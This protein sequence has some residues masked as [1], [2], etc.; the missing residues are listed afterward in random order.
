M[1]PIL[2]PH[3]KS[4]NE[5]IANFEFLIFN[6]NAT[7]PPRAGQCRCPKMPRKCPKITRFFCQSVRRIVETKKATDDGRASVHLRWTCKRPGVLNSKRYALNHHIARLD[8]GGASGPT[9]FARSFFTQGRGNRRWRCGGRLR[10]RSNASSKTAENQ[11]RRTKKKNPGVRPCPNSVRLTAHETDAIRRRL[12]M[13]SSGR[14][15]SQ[16]MRGVWN[17]MKPHVPENAC[18]FVSSRKGIE[19]DS[20]ACVR[21]QGDPRF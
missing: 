18:L 2:S 16:Y 5:P 15:R 6:Q 11:R 1:C 17:R 20:S 14:C 9:R 21:R 3:A 13:I 19:N 4:R 12:T 10:N 8:G 7:R